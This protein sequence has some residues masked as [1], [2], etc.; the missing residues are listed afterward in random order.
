MDQQYSIGELSRE[1]AVSTR[2]IR[3]YEDRGLVAPRREGLT[4]IFS[5]R[6][7]ARLKLALRGK[8][9]G[10][11]LNEIRALLDLYEVPGGEAVQLREFC[12]RLQERR[13]ALE[14]RRLDIDIVL[15]EMDTLEARCSDLLQ[16]QD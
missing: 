6:D 1:F 5:P 10:F 7:R 3:F 13:S 9:L 14:Q 8:R 2:T 11:S 12:A 15:K 16:G 4:R